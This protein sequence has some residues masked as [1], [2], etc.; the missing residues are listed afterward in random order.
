MRIPAL[1]AILCLLLVSSAA[2]ACSTTPGA[3][4]IVYFVC[5][6]STGGSTDIEVRGITPYFQMHYPAKVVNDNRT[7]GGSHVGINYVYQQPSDGR[8]VLVSSATSSIKKLLNPEAA[9][10]SGTFLESFI[11]VGS[12][13]SAGGNV[14]VTPRD[15]SIRT[16]D[17]F[18]TASH[19]RTLSVGM[20]PPGSS[21]H[22][23]VLMLEKAVGSR[24]NL[25]PYEGGA[26]LAFAVMG[27]HVDAGVIGF[28][29]IADTSEFHLLGVTSTEP[30]PE[31]PAPT[32][33][34]LGFPQIASDFVIGAFVKAGTPQNVVDGL[35][36]AFRRAHDEP[37]YQAW[38]ASRGIAVSAYK[39][40]R[41]WSAY[42]RDWAGRVEAI[43]PDL[44]RSMEELGA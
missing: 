26:D 17:D 1:A 34:Q 19:Q 42:L 22:M 8:H 31:F 4:D 18:I 16:L 3:A 35:D 20:P 36:E 32:F 10:Y 7:G 33:T 27:G 15:S 30:V 43:M 28:Q 37:E 9:A 12:W 13:V 40:Q 25:V 38:L 23:D 41:A 21:D 6:F 29:S 44:I 39:D 2:P 24:F 14:L 5:P 11:P